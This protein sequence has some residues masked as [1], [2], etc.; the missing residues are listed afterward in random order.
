MPFKWTYGW[1]RGAKYTLADAAKF[2]K[3]V[4]RAK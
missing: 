1:V 3:P 4:Q 2:G